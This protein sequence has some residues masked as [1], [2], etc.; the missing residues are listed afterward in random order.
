[1]HPTL[2]RQTF[3]AVVLLALLFSGAPAFAKEISYTADL[4]A[5]SE[6]PPNDSKGTG[7]V[8]AI[9]DT[10][11]KTFSWTITYSDLTGPATAA[12]FHGPAAPRE[13]APPVVPLSGDLGSPIKGKSTLTDTQAADLEAGHWYFNI[14]TAAHPTGEIRG[15]LMKK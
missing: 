9:Y 11:S 12:H 6:V 10:K 7:A 5:A 1:M 3:S 4:T 8:E 2:S 15:Q 13:N 14:H